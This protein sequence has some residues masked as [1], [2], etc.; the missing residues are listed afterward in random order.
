MIPISN[1]LKKAIEKAAEEAGNPYQLSIMVGVS[2]ATVIKW[3]N[4]ATSKIYEDTLIRLLPLLLPH[5]DKDAVKKYQAIFEYSVNECKLDLAKV[6]E[7]SVNVDDLH[8]RLELSENLFKKINLYLSLHE[9]TGISAPSEKIV[10]KE[11]EVTPIAAGQLRP[12]P[13]LSFA[14]AA[15]YEPAIEPICDYL[16]ETTEETAM[17]SD[18][19]ENY[20][21]LRVDGDSM[22]PDYPHGSIALVAAGEFPQ[23]GDI[24]AAKLHDGQVVIKEYHRKDNVIS[25]ESINPAGKSFKWHCKEQPGYVQWMWPVIE[26]TLKPRERR[27]AKSKA[28]IS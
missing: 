24:V 6:N 22:S 8:D 19:R 2:N 1:E 4:G 28:G 27:W 12:V 21:A 9:K 18:V 20:F 13:V 16:R 25:L 5:L 3:L 11:N 10:M 23:R 15:G 26:I 14:Q 17:F 7:N